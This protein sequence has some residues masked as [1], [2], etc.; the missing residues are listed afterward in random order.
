MEM[1]S[2]FY[3]KEQQRPINFDIHYHSNFV[4]PFDR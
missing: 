3:I 2:L 4:Q 1:L